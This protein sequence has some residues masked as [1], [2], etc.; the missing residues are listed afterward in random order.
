MSIVRGRATA[1]F[2]RERGVTLVSLDLDDTLLDSDALA[3]MRLQVA[4]A[5]ARR[6][7]PDL[8]AARAERA[9]AEALA[10]NP[11]AVGRMAQ[12]FRI[13]ELDSQSP[14]GVAI[15]GAYNDA[16]VEAIEWIE[17]ARDSLVRLRDHF[18][19]A[20]V[21]NGPSELQWSKLRKFGIDELVDHVV[22]SGD[23][24]VHKPD[25][26]I[27]EHLLRVAGVS[28]EGAAHV[29]DSM[30]SD[31]AGARAAGL[32]AVWYPPRRREHDPMDEHQPHAIVDVL[33]DLIAGDVEGDAD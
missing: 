27:F 1:R 28:A 25:P 15:R 31:V 14:G 4:L 12:F 7:F 26:G 33:D 22:V 19:L 30:Y 16:L 21:T 5:E 20:V 6:Q 13:L 10:A 29:G 24:G 2:L 23:V 11:V 17:G 18:S 3:E 32:T 9:Y 8:D